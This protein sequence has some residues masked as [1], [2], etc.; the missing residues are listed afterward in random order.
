MRLCAS[1]REQL[2]YLL[3]DH[4]AFEEIRI[5]PAP[6]TRRVAKDKV[7]EVLLR[8]QAVVDEFI[9]L[10]Q[11]VRHVGNVEVADVGAEDG[12]EPRA[13]RVHLAIERPRVGRIV[14]FA[15][16]V[17]VIDQQVA[18]IL[19]LFDLARPEIIER[20]SGH[21][22]SAIDGLKFVDMPFVTVGTVA[23]DHL[24]E[25]GE[26]K[27]RGI[28]RL[29]RLQIALFPMADQVAVKRAAP[30]HAAFEER[31]LERGETARHAGQEERFAYG[32]AGGAEMADMVVDE[33]RG[34][35]AESQTRGC[36]MEG[37]IDLQFDAFRPYGVVIAGA[38][39]AERVGPNSVAVE[40]S[41]F[42]R[43]LYRAARYG[44]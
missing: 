14:G 25:R 9:R 13:I 12:I 30:A 24:A 17:E 6:E 31:E 16:E 11:H 35:R 27:I 21:R 7:A 44:P 32:L 2:R 22:L 26:V 19:R 36:G 29:D 37:R 3:F 23:L 10:G 8:D 33:I 15:S 1:F 42:L 18:D 39:D 4:R 34:R 38:V 43:G 41:F 40:R 5:R 20:R 28:G